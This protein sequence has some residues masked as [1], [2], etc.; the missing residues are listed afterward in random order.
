MDFH[1]SRPYILL[2]LTI[3]GVLSG[4]ILSGQ[5]YTY[6]QTIQ[7]SEEW[8]KRVEIPVITRIILTADSLNND[9]L[10]VTLWYGGVRNDNPQYIEFIL[11]PGETFED[12]NPLETSKSLFHGLNFIQI[13]INPAFIIN[14]T[15]LLSGMIEVEGRDWTLLE[16][17]YFDIFYKFVEFLIILL[18]SSIGFVFYG[19]LLALAYSRGYYSQI[20]LKQLFLILINCVWIIV[21]VFCGMNAVFFSSSDPL[22]HLIPHPYLVPRILFLLPGV[23]FIKWSLKP[24][25]K[26]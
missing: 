5:P 23:Y 14:S 15:E 10:N 24:E 13:Q 21:E 19:Y 12:H 8:E 3:L 4:W 17:V 22:L 6:T 26:G 25:K 20:T 9:S 7:F 16:R 1:L 11:N 18:V 2:I